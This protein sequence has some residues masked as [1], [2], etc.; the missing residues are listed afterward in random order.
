MSELGTVHVS[1]DAQQTPIVTRLKERGGFV[2]EI[3]GLVHTTLSSNVRVLGLL[4]SH[5]HIIFVMKLSF[6]CLKQ[7]TGYDLGIS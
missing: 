4:L 1:I 5:C 6:I 3:I 7:W 2:A